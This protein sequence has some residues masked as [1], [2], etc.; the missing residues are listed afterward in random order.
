MLL[1]PLDMASL[2]SRALSA[3]SIPPGKAKDG[4]R[5]AAAAAATSGYGVFI[6]SCTVRL[7]HIVPEMATDGSRKLL[8]PSLDMTSL[9][10][11][12]ASALS[13]SPHKRPQKGQR[14]PDS[15]SFQ[16]RQT[17]VHKDGIRALFL[18]ASAQIL[19]LINM[20][21]IYCIR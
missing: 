14:R 6:L 12:A 7:Q 9:F 5:K 16:K 20:L 8:L 1:S 2:V 18:P 3:L 21:T 11:L 4:L 17:R 19:F 13:T 15:I 10:S